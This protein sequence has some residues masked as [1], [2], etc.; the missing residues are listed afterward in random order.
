VYES[1]WKHKQVTSLERLSKELVFC[2]NSIGLTEPAGNWRTATETL[3]PVRA[4]NSAI[5]AFETL[6]TV[7]G[8]APSRVLMP[9]NVKKLLSRM[10]TFG[11]T[12][13]SER[14]SGSPPITVWKIAKEITSLNINSCLNVLRAMIEKL[15]AKVE[16]YRMC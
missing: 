13:K 1:F 11:G 6:K 7:G 15:K 2:V 3:W 9:V 5:L 14:I 10:V 4:G 16:A 8:G 12:I